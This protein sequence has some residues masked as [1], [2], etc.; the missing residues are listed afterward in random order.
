SIGGSS[1]RAPRTLAALLALLVVAL[2]LV[3]YSAGTTPP[4]RSTPAPPGSAPTSTF[5]TAHG[6]PAAP[7]SA[8]TSAWIAPAVANGSVEFYQNTSS[9]AVPP[10]AHAGC[11]TYNYGYQIDNYCYPQAVSPTVVTLANGKI[12]IGY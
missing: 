7:R 11:T 8:P 1:A 10:A 6:P 2:L 9:F 5:A 4:A 3:P 12:R